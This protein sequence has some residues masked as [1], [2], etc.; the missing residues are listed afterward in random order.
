MLS[1]VSL[2]PV[3]FACFVALRLCVVVAVFFYFSSVTLSNFF[4][5]YRI[6]E[7]RVF[8]FFLISHKTIKYVLLVLGAEYMCA[9][10][11][12]KTKTYSHNTD[13]ITDVLLHF[14]R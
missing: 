10:T 12:F 9:L 13:L 5:V 11:L 7:R 6:V 3:R 4:V 1:P 2:R 14:S 8:S